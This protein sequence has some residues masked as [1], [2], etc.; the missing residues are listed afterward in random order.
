MLIDGVTDTPTRKMLSRAHRRRSPMAWRQ[1]EGLLEL[2]G[3]VAL[4]C[5]PR[6]ERGFNEG[7]AAEYEATH[8]IQLA[9]G[10][11]AAGTR[12]KGGAE[13]ARQGPTIQLR[14]LFERIQT[15]ACG[16]IGSD[17]DACAVQAFHR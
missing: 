16:G 8:D 14:D 3:H 6:S 15:V 7:H 13:L 12:A 5:E 10:A 17:H 4:I 1:P 11:V 2:A 9:H